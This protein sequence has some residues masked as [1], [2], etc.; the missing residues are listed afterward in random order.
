MSEEK[1][2]K[3]QNSFPAWKAFVFVFGAA[4]LS[5]L[6]HVWF[7]ERI[8]WGIGWFVACVL[9]YETPPRIVPRGQLAKTLFWS[10]AVGLAVFIFGKPG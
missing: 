8:S 9:F 3:N 7:P 5:K 1:N 10:A 4:L 2:D 6:L